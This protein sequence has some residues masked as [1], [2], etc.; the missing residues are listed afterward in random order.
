MGDDPLLAPRKLQLLSHARADDD[1]LSVGDLQLARRKREIREGLVCGN[2]K[3]AIVTRQV[4]VNGVLS[5]V[6]DDGLFF[7]QHGPVCPGALGSR[8]VFAPE[9][10]DPV[11]KI[12]NGSHF[13]T[14]SADGWTLETQLCEFKKA[15]IGAETAN[16]IFLIR[17]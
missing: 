17:A 12:M 11:V 7:P 6:P 14:V 9:L 3:A 10:T 16:Q 1:V 13:N 2:A 5:L 15:N 8:A 4:A